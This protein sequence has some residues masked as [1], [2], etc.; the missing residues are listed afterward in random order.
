MSSGIDILGLTSHKHQYWFG[1]NDDETLGLQEEQHRLH[2]P[3]K[4]ILAQNLRRK[5]ITASVRHP[6][7]D[8]E[9]NKIPD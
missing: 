9:V 1:E 4:V 6:D 5:P 7:A 8:S 2:N 3:S